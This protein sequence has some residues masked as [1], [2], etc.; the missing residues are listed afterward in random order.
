MHVRKTENAQ[1]G[2]TNKNTKYIVHT[3]NKDSQ[4]KLSK[5]EHKKICT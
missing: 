5:L 1:N 2:L 3:Y 4:S